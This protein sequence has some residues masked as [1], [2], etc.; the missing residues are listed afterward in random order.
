MTRRPMSRSSRVLRRGV[1]PVGGDELRR[2]PPGPH[3][4]EHVRVVVRDEVHRHLPADRDGVVEALVALDELLHGDR[5]DA[6]AAEDAQGMLQAGG[7]V[8]PH[9]VQGAGAAARLEDHR[10]A[11]LLGERADLGGAARRGRGG[12]RHAGLAQ[13]LLH[14]RLVPAQPGG[15]YRRAGDRAGLP[16]LCGGHGVRLDRGLEPVHPQLVLH[17]ADR[18]R[19]RPDVGDRPHLLVVVQPAPQLAV[20]CV[21]GILADADHRRTGPGQRA[22]EVALA[23]GEERLDEHDVHDRMLARADRE[24]A[25]WRRPGPRRGAPVPGASGVCPWHGARR[26]CCAVLARCDH[27]VRRRRGR[28]AR[29]RAGPD[30]LRAGGPAAWRA[31]TQARRA[32]A[33]RR[34]ARRRADRRGRRRA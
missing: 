24:P 22:G 11:H 16:D 17:P 29:Y 8:G 33:D 6:L 31:A 32:L 23:G 1:D 25:V 30:H 20:Q 34:P 19:H 12:R 7:I 21:G 14:R 4:L 3:R 13:R 26:V 27:A 18:G 5:L 2:D 28:C 10:V 15:A 9:R